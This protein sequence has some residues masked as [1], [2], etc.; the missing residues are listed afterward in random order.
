MG[1]CFK[2]S[3]KSKKSQK[4]KKRTHLEDDAKEEDSNNHRAT[5]IFGHSLIG[6]GKKK[7]V[8]QDSLSIMEN[9]DQNLSYFA[10]YD[11]HGLAGRDASLL[12]NESIE[13]YLKKNSKKIAK[14]TDTRAIQKFMKEM[15]MKTQ[16]KFKNMRIY[17]FTLSGTCAITILIIGKMCYIGNLG[18]SRAVMG[19]I[20][21][22]GQ[23]IAIEISI[24]HKPYRDVER[25]R[26]LKAGGKIERSLVDDR[27]VGP[28]RV[29]KADEDVP[30]I[31]V[32]R[33]LGDLV[34]HKIG[35]ISDPEVTYKEIQEEDKFIVIASDGL[36][37]VMSSAEVVGF[38]LQCDNKETAVQK[39]V[40]E[41]RERWDLLNEIKKRQTALYIE[42]TENEKKKAERLQNLEKNLVC[43][44]ITAV[45]AYLQ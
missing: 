22:D 9:F 30:G 13:T 44:D 10:V 21:S 16:D 17:D 15:F 19:N 34:A 36:W 27:E 40:E 43:D 14:I 4:K 18:D 35:I 7:T 41:A 29:W 31:A 6:Y 37:D 11:G 20:D 32:S 2:K 26:I 28:L 25:D 8:C 12:A 45:I 5:N 39:L 33:T 42:N 1:N 24:D 23:V 38:I 3:K